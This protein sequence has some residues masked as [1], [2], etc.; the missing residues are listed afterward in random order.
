MINLQTPRNKDLTTTT[1]QLKTIVSLRLVH[2]AIRLC[3]KSKTICNLHLISKIDIHFVT[4]G[5]GCLIGGLFQQKSQCD[6]T[7]AHSF[8]AKCVAAP[9]YSFYKVLDVADQIIFQK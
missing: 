9:K 7:L 2:I 5:R 6:E 3:S 8:L 4:H 1:S